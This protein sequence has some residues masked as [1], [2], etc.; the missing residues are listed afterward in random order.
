MRTFVTGITGFAGGYLAEH[1]LSEGDE[2]SGC[3]RNGVWPKHLSHIAS[4]ASLHACDLGDAEAAR[5]LFRESSPDV[6]FHL[7]A[8]AHPKS[9]LE[10]PELAHRAN[11]QAT[12]NLLDA[13]LENRLRTRLIYVSTSYIYARP[14]T[15]DLPLNTGFPVRTDHPYAASKWAGELCCVRYAEEFGLDTVRVRP[16][17]HTGPRQPTG[18]IVPDWAR[19]IASIEAHRIPPILC[20]GN[21]ASRRD[22]TD[23]RDIVRAYRLVARLA[24][25]NAVYN[26]GSGASRSGREIL[27]ILQRLSLEKF[28][29]RQDPN[30]LR[31]DEIPD[32]RADTCPLVELTQWV[33]KISIEATLSDT[34]DY[35]RA[36]QGKN[37]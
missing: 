22:Y 4:Q 34:L 21:L 26:I 2:V 18:Y 28:E 24:P 31:S 9:C 5:R 10:A 17:N 25:A 3:S 27:D 16:F 8:L 19:Q 33:P 14:S 1:L 32:M 37:G 15:A 11:V 7:A 23:V 30:R 20:V 29:I 13:I 6:I 36:K 12:Q 35:W